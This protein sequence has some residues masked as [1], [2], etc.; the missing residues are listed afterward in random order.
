MRHDRRFAMSRRQARGARRSQSS[1]FVPSGPFD[2]LSLSPFAWWRGDSTDTATN[3]DLLDRS[4][5]NH[6]LRQAAASPTL[7]PTIVQ[8]A[9]IGGLDAIR[10]DGVDDYLAS[11]DAAATWA[12]T[13]NG[14]GAD[15]WLMVIPRT[16]SA[17]L[18]IVDNYT[19]GAQTAFRIIFGG[20][21]STARLVVN[22]NAGANAV[23]ANLVSS[24]VV[25]TPILLRATLLEGGSPEYSWN[26][27]N[28]G[29]PATG[30]ATFGA[31]NPAATLNM[32]RRANGT[33]FANFDFVDGFAFDRVL[34]AGEATSL[35]GYFT[36][37]YGHP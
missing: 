35:Y 4:G 16:V 21:A 26:K 32:G 37:L 31:N 33:A 7:M 23:D 10:F 28:G 3:F 9:E 22:D 29:S 30:T 1:R 17:G 19:A 24:F 2:P 18:S 15:M 8:P 14:L 5:N 12:F 6:R 20:T 25:A 13:N 34:T 36:D 11:I 27:D